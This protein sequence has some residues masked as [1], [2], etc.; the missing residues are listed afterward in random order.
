MEI[1]GHPTQDMLDE[2]ERRGALRLDGTTSGPNE[3][4][5]RFVRERVEERSGLWLFLLQEAFETGFD[6]APV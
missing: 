2:L 1:E 5:L 3:D 6:E 4:S